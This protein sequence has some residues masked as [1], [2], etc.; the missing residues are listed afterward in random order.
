MVYLCVT[1]LFNRDR[2]RKL[3]MAGERAFQGKE[4]SQSDVCTLGAGKWLLWLEGWARR[5]LK[6]EAGVRGSTPSLPVSVGS[7]L[8]LRGSG[9][10]CSTEEVA[11][12]YSSLTAVL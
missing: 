6:K 11:Q 2:L 10:C 1:A 5:W 7:C 8:V 9:V 3:R 12:V 4:N